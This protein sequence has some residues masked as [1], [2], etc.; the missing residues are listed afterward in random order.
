[1]QGHHSSSLDLNCLSLCFAQLQ[2]QLPLQTA[3][4][5]L[6]TL[7]TLGGSLHPFGTHKKVLGQHHTWWV[8]QDGSQG[9]SRAETPLCLL[10]T[11]QSPSSLTSSPLGTVGPSDLFKNFHVIQIPSQLLEFSP[12][13]SGEAYIICKINF[14]RKA[15][16]F[17]KPRNKVECRCF[18]MKFRKATLKMQVVMGPPENLSKQHETLILVSLKW[19]KCSNPSF[20]SI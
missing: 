10:M 1:M 4:A 17:S 6:N 11:Q 7:R 15:T 20:L 19:W 9:M 18:C 3:K 2:N 5:S 8:C 12:L 13:S 16:H 14:G